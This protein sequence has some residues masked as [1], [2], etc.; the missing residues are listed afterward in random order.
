MIL[1]I[2]A[3]Y[4][5]TVVGAGFASGQSIMQ[6]F[7]VYG[8]FGGIGICMTTL[9]F[10]WLGTKMMVLSRRIQAFSYQ[11]FNT[12]LFGNVFGKVANALTFLIL[13]GVTAVMLSGTGSIFE[14]QLGLPYQIGIVISIALSYLVMSRELNGILAVNSLVCAHDACIYYS[15]CLSSC[16]NGRDM[17]DDRF[18]Y[19]AMGQPEMDA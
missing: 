3:T 14:E 7:T 1:K 16:R 15:H 10:I 17:E 8:A 11:E 13:F 18:P 2:A 19:T 5:G 4:I 9:L 12:F 6:F